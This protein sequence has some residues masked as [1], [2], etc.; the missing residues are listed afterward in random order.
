[1]IRTGCVKFPALVLG[2]P[3]ARWRDR[4]RY[5]GDIVGP[6]C[7]WSGS[8]LAGCCRCVLV[9]LM[10]SSCVWPQTRGRG[11]GR[12]M[13]SRRARLLVAFPTHTNTP[14]FSRLL[15]PCCS[16][17]LLPSVLLPWS[18]QV[19]LTLF[20]LPPA[21]G[22]PT[23]AQSVRTEPKL[24]TTFPPA[25]SETRKTSCLLFLSTQRQPNKPDCWLIMSVI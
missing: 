10:T 4:R 21:L 1:M 7:F 9:P 5:C 12:M 16:P 14:P 22:F 15:A 8:A 18:L 20:F 24:T 2:S 23:T 19:F 11:R 13:S 25:Q 3:S 17:A 6:M